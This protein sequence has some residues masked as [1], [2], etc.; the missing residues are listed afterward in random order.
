MARLVSTQGDDPAPTGTPK[1]LEPTSKRARNARQQRE[2]DTQSG[3]DTT[4]LETWRP[5]ADPNAEPESLAVVV[6][7]GAPGDLRRAPSS[8]FATITSVSYCSC[9]PSISAGPTGA[10]TVFWG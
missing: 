10:S 9:L 6:G 1:G 2:H 3:R 7:L 4:G 5:V 8:T